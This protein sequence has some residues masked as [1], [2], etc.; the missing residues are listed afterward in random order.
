MIKSL[1]L[2]PLAYLC[3]VL[4]YVYKV[5]DSNNLFGFVLDFL[6]YAAVILITIVII[7]AYY[8]LQPPPKVEADPAPYDEV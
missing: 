3:G 6:S 1:P 7:I 8:Y 5:S 4:Q 2:I